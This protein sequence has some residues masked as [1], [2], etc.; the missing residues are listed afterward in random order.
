MTDV[1]ANGRP[2]RPD[3]SDIPPAVLLAALRRV[4]E[5]REPEVR[6]ELAMDTRLDELNVD[7][8]LLAEFVVELE[9]RMSML[10]E[11]HPADL[12]VRVG[13]LLDAVRPT[14]SFDQA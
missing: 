13:D 2:T 7:S 11:F 9:E 12:L 10:F 8:M 1:A 4:L 3:D 6:V 5:V 14:V